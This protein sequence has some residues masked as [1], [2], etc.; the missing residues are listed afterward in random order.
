[1]VG[2]YLADHWA[3][4]RIAILD[5]ATTWSARASPAACGAGCTSA[6]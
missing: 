2:D 1:M 5:D 3:V 4:R 6:A